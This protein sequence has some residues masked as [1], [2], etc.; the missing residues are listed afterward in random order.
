[1]DKRLDRLRALY[2]E[3]QSCKVCHSAPGCL[4]EEDIKRVA[5]IVD[6]RSIESEVFVVG[7]A[8]GEHTQRLSGLPYTEEGGALSLT[9]KG[10]DNWLRLFGYTIGSMDSSREYRYVYSSDIVQ[11]FPGKKVTDK[12][13]RPPTAQEITNCIDR[14]YLL[15]EMELVNPQLVILMGKAS[16]DGFYEHVLGARYPASLSAHIDEAVE[17][18]RIQV[19]KVGKANLAILPMQHPSGA[20]PRFNC[21]KGN[22]KLIELV[23]GVL[24]D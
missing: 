20:N 21:M 5:R 3:A 19:Y 11:C 15:R 4:I 14:G 9:G 16:R 13:D 8:L 17:K 10:L 2:K 23:K 6:A 18:G 12:G 7:Q 22:A 1:M 24:N